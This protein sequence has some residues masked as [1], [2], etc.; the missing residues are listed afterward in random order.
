[1]RLLQ[2]AQSSRIDA[3]ACEPG[4]MPE[5]QGVVRQEPAPGQTRRMA[6]VTDITRYRVQ[7]VEHDGFGFFRPGECHQQI[8][9]ARNGKTARLA[10][11][12]VRHHLDICLR[13]F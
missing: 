5:R 6:Q 8:V 13:R 12:P 1:M 7:R 9:W 11:T 3:P 10:L 2:F 4:R